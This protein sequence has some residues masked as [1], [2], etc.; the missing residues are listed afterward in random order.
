MKNAKKVLKSIS[1]AKGKALNK[2]KL[3]GSKTFRKKKDINSKV[4]RR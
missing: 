3:K 1:I 4:K 2:F